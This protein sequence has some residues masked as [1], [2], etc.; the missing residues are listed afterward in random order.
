MRR[1][2]SG[3]REFKV[4]KKGIARL[5]VFGILASMAAAPAAMRA[6]SGGT[7]LKP[8]EMQKLLPATM[9][10]DGQ[11]ATTQLRNSGGV[12]FSD[13]NLV[14]AV[15]IDTSGYSTSIAARYQAQFITE[16]PISIRGKRLPGGVYGIGFIAGHKFVVT[17]VG[18]HEV[19]SVSSDSDA[20]LK[21][22][23]PLEFLPDPSGGFRLYAGRQYV[24]LSR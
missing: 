21:R 19:L 6:Q 24:V 10:Y 7:V 2:A 16:V 18:A 4:L 1:N 15:M 14:L 12:R 20:A 8:E 5:A 11:T 13:G 22:P 17:D 3:K 23:R 9:F